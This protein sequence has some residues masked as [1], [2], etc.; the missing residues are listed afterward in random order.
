M[1]RRISAR[2]ALGAVVVFVMTVPTLA[3]GSANHA[4]LVTFSAP[5]GLPGVTLGSGSY[6]FELAT[7]RRSTDVVTV[8]NVNRSIVY[9]SGFTREIDRPR[10]QVR[11]IVLSD[12]APGAV[13]QVL[14]WYPDGETFGQQFLYKARSVG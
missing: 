10:G 3:G 2:A 7:P 9:F 5:V 1:G 8:T 4:S 13:P 6:I 14:A 12:A 11:A